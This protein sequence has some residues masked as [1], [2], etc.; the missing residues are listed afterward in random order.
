MTGKGRSTLRR[1]RR[2]RGSALASLARR[3]EEWDRYCEGSSTSYGKT[4]PRY[5]YGHGY[6]QT[7]HC[8]YGQIDPYRYGLTAPYGYGQTAPYSYGQTVPYGYETSFTIFLL[9]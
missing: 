3:D 1:P 2:S 7:A 9:L 6:S 4:A 5:G 8:G